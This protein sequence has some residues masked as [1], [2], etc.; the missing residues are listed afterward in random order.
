MRNLRLLLGVSVFWLALSVLSDGL[1]SLVLPTLLLNQARGGAGGES[2]GSATTLGLLTFGGLAAGMLVQPL[3]GQWSDRQRGRLSRQAV[4]GLG[5]LLVLLALAVL[6]LAQ[7]LPAL[8]AAYLG[9][10]IAA[11]IAQAGQ[12]GLIPD[13]VPPAQ[14]G[15]AA[16]W[17]GLM[18][19][20]GAT[21][22]FLLLGGLL[23]GD[24]M[25]PALLAV[26][27]VLLACYG[28]AVLLVR[29]QPRLGRPAVTPPPAHLEGS[30]PP[31]APSLAGA[32]RLDLRQHAAFARVVLARFFFLLGT[33]AVGRF[34][35]LYI[36]DRLDLD[37]GRAAEE[38]GLLLAVLTL[39]T[40]LAAPLGGWAADRLGRTPLMVLGSLL[41][42]GGTLGLIGAGSQPLILLCGL[43]M[44]L[45]SA[46]FA[47]ANW[48]LT[49][50]LAPPAEAARFMA[51]A[52]FGTAGGAAAAGLFGFLVDWGNG[53]A[54]GYGYTLLFGAAAVALLAA[55]PAVYR[56]PAPQPSPAPVDN[57]RSLESAI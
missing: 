38:T 1:N 33:Y 21:L 39:L 26:A 41:S 32:F 19:T 25:A 54:G 3:A 29:E 22:G 40:A 5:L 17:K 56:L 13:L 34:L 53:Q 48:A 27:A 15:L 57:A 28:L 45:G 16:G 35:L 49:T 8:F 7:G 44:A 30:S 20:G 2:A 10:Q 51:L 42:A 12:Q 52:N 4:I 47:S 18:D 23:G 24:S 37:G 55:I 9:V 50:E 6:G 46:A 43:L 36:A 14:R 11:S 31:V